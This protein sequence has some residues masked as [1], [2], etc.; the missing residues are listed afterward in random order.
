MHC[1]MLAWLDVIISFYLLTAI[2][3]YFM[4]TYFIRPEVHVPWFEMV[5]L[6]KFEMKQP[7]I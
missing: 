4:K 6:R 5:Q 7:V 3:S 1:E 2:V